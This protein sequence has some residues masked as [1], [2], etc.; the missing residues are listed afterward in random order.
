MASLSTFLIQAALTAHD[1]VLVKPI[2]PARGVFE[3]ISAIASA[4]IMVALLVFVVVAVPVAWHFRKMYRKVNHMLDRIQG[5]ITPLMHHVSSIADNVNFVTTSIRTDVQKV[6][7]TIASANERVLEAVKAAENRLNEF[8]ALLSV[9][10]DEAEQVFVSTA[11]T[12]RGVRGGAEAFRRR[13]MDLAEDELDAAA[14]ADEIELM[15]SEEEDDGH[16]GSSEPSEE[17]FS[18]APRVGP[19]AVGQRRRRGV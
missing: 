7:A 2:L 3:Q 10:Q 12:V 13:G 4:I 5:D 1:T 8:N 6:N 16:D 14:L 19:R 11:A 9:V 18:A 17:T 15:E